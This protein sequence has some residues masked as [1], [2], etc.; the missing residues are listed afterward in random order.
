M[1]QG[2]SSVNAL[3]QKAAEAGCEYLALTDTNGLYGLIHFLE[4]A[5]RHGLRPIVGATLQTHD[6]KENF[7]PTC[8]PH[9]TPSSFL[10]T[11]HPS[12]LTPNP[13][14]L[15]P[16]ASRLTPHAIILAKTAKGYELLTELLTRR[17]LDEKFSL[18]RDF[19]E[20]RQQLAVLS[21]HPDLIKGLRSRAECWVEVVPGPAG[22]QALKLARSLGIPPVATNAVYFADP[23]D[24]T[25]HRLVRAIALNRTLSTLPPEAVVQPGQWLKP[26]EVMAG[27]FP[28]AP[29]ALANTVKLAEGC[30]TTWDHF[31]PVFPHYADQAQDH[32]ALLWDECRRGIAWRYGE[33]NAILERRLEEELTLIHAK[34][35]VD[36]FLVV[37]DIVRRRP[38]HCGRGSAAASLVS[39]L[40][41]ITHVD[42]IRHNLL[43]GRFLNPQRKDPPDIDV[44]FPWDERD[45]LH[46]EL[47][48]YYGTERLATVANHVGFGARAAVREVARV[49]GMPAAEIKE[50]TRRMSCYTDP[51]D[52]LRRVASHPKFRGCPLDPPWPEIMQL[53]TRLEALPRHLATHCG[54]VI[55]APDRVSR[56]VPVERSAKGIHII[57]W[58]KDQSETAGL[59]KIDLLGNRSLAVIRD[60][61]AAIRSS[62]GKAIDY[63][64]LNPVDDPATLELLRRGD[65]MGVFYVESPAMRQL[66]QRTGCGDFDHL[67]IHSSIIRPAANRF[68]QEYLRRLHGAPYEPLHPRL[69][70]LLAE[71]YGILVYQEDVVRVAMALAGFS[72]GDADGLRKVIS[73][74]SPEQLADYHQRFLDGC[75]RRGI[76]DDVVTAVWE[77]FLSFAGY[78]FCKPHSASYALVSFKSAYLKAHY[79]AEFM[80]AVISNGGG[81]Y[82]THAY[83]S[84]AR[85]MG[86]TVLGPDVNAS[87]WSYRG[88]GTTIRMGLQQLQHLR[89]DVLQGIIEERERHGPFKGLEDFLQRAALTPADAAV[90][91]KSGALDSLAETPNPELQDLAAE[92]QELLVVNRKLSTYP[93]SAFSPFLKGSRGDFKSCRHANPPVSPFSKGDS[94]SCFLYGQ[95]P[96]ANNPQ[97]PARFNRP[98]LLWFVETWLNRKAA[99]RSNGQ[100]TGMGLSSRSHPAFSVPPLPDLSRTRQWQQEIET[101]GLVLSVHPLAMWEPAMQNL[102]QRPVPASRLAQV[103]GKRVWVAGWPIT[104]KEVMTRE[105]EPMEFFSFEDQTAIYETVFFPRAFRRF[106]QE[107]D[108]ERAYLLYGRVESEFGTVSL[109]VERVRKLHPLEAVQK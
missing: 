65:T 25:L 22:R 55:L 26:A 74:K 2:V 24:Y 61:L 76:A 42:P 37:A 106:C 47:R 4:A 85:R 102:L 11:P 70:E 69:K 63:A 67:V 50:V 80:A 88:S 82:R 87:D 93:H 46:E 64:L 12:P 91:V 73:K 29:E 17:H 31:P 75:R 9:P 60:T 66:Q 7:T 92:G 54:G 81:Y 18:F 23:E 38:I 99:S 96:G 83:I 27:H 20:A 78:S 109:N 100:Q 14:P 30:H 10:L 59:I 101:L 58:E 77:M 71:T 51:P 19:P 35:Y 41:G 94:G 97:P 21:S 45:A 86:L 8:T 36:Y 53:A 90:L 28:D 40:L 32:L 49:Y 1:M 57:Q 72:W 108:M 39:Y 56:Y 52:I 98:Q 68:I 6:H 48:Q 16:H 84:E 103:V 44:D 5:R 43:F 13:S 3:C 95:T 33:S 62:T 104:R 79:P 34:G 89:R 107:L 15:T 105:R